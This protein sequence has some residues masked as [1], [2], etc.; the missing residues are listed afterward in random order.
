MFLWVLLV[1]RSL[2]RGLPNADTLLDLQNRLRQFPTDLREFYLQMVE[3]I[4]IYHEKLTQTFRIAVALSEPSS[5][6]L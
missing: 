3:N 5:V 2:R 4:E 1:V 6:L